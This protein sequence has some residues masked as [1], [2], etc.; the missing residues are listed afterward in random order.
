MRIIS[1]K[2]QRRKINPPK[3][4]PVRPTTDFA[5]EALFNILHNRFSSYNTFDILDLYAGTGS[6]SLEFASRGA[7]TVTSIDSNNQCI[8]FIKKISAE[9]DLPI[10]TLQTEAEKYATNNKLSYDIVF[11]DPPYDILEED[12]LHLSELVYKN[13]L[14][15]GG[16]FIL[17]HSKYVLKN[18]EIPHQ[19]KR[20]NYGNTVFSFIEKNAGL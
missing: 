7:K 12:L 15:D 2:H 1:G 13:L 17:E 14:V 9:L 6:I 19:V 16:I 20:R 11:A 3:N 4:L 5:K 18:V 8:H 10:Q